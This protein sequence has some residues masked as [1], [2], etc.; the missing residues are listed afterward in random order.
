MTDRPPDRR[1][2]RRPDAVDWVCALVAVVVLTSFAGLLVTGRYL[3]DGPVLFAVSRRHGL[4][5]GDLYVG[6]GWALGVVAVL[7]ATLRRRRD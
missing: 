1:R 4:H 2:H 6:T 3:A 5:E 7:L